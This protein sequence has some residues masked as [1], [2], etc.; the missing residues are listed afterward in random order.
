MGEKN[1]NFFQPLI[2]PCHSGIICFGRKVLPG[3]SEYTRVRAAAYFPIICTCKVAL[4][5]HSVPL[6][7]CFSCRL[8]DG[9]PGKEKVLR[10]KTNNTCTCV[11]VHF[12]I[13]MDVNMVCVRGFLFLLT[14]HWNVS[15][16][17]Y[18]KFA[19]IQQLPEKKH[20][21]YTIL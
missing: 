21:S 16:E 4:R 2:P 3:R 5:E 14:I 9:R 18:E 8:Y 10:R 11:K 17:C 6:G 7:N 20:Y 13:I 15:L 19:S 1:K 12:R